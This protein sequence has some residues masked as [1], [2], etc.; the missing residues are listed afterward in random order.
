[1]S[2]DERVSDS[3]ASAMDDT[4]ARAVHDLLPHNK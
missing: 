4:V 2:Y 3:Q 1:V